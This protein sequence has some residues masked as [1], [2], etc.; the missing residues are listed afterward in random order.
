MNSIQIRDVDSRLW[1]I[2]TQLV[3][4]RGSAILGFLNRYQAG[5]RYHSNSSASGH[6][7]KFHALARGAIGRRSNGSEVVMT[8]ADAIAAGILRRPDGSPEAQ[9]T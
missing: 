2:P 8:R 4:L 6:S 1:P 5:W 3:V 7:A 9:L